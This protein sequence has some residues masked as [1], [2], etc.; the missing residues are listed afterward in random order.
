MTPRFPCIASL[1]SLISVGTVVGLLAGCADD[2]VSFSEPVG[3]NLKAKSSDTVNRVV[4]DE[5]GITTESGNPYGA[6]VAHARDALGGADPAR[7]EVDKVEVFLGATSKGVLT[8]GEIYD[9]NLELVFKM[10]DTDNSYPVAHATI[11]SATTSGPVGLA[12]DFD[13]A[14]I[15]SVDHAKLLGGG[16]KVIARG[17]TATGFETKGAEADL[18]ITF[19]FAAFE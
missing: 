4:T 17:A 9:G 3:I 5:K 11:T 13:G 14:A 18:Q 1:P 8:L 15:P 6:F 2:P 12:V 16:F 7:I 19:T 10:N